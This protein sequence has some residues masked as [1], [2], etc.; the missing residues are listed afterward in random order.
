MAEIKP[1]SQLT[2]FINIFT[3]EPGDQPALLDTLKEETAELVSKLDGFVSATLRASTDGRRA[4][5]FAQWTDL[6]A[7]NQ[8]RAG[9]QGKQLIQAVNRYAKAVDIHL[10]EVSWAQEATIEVD[11]KSTR[12][13]SSHL[14]ISYAV[15]CL[16]K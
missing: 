9:Q 2:T 12:L 7:F 14:V 8:R 5:N 15:F 13:N 3:C 6:A 11:R 16:K 1:G 4:I 10:Y